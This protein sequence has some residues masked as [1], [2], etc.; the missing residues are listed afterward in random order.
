MTAYTLLNLLEY[1]VSFKYSTQI[2][3]TKKYDIKYSTQ[4]LGM[5]SQYY[6]GIEYRLSIVRI[7]YS[8]VEYEKYSFQYPTQI[9]SIQSMIFNTLL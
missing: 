1:W 9:L 2:S 3:S 5:L 6:S 8:N 4:M 7:L